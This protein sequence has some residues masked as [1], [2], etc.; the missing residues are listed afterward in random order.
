MIRRAGTRPLTTS[1]TFRRST[2]SQA[3]T[4]THRTRRPSRLDDRP[5]R[6]WRRADLL[7]SPTASR[8]EN[9]CRPRPS[10][11][12]RNFLRG[13]RRHR[14]IGAEGPSSASTWR[15]ATSSPRPFSDWI[16]ERDRSSNMSDERRPSKTSGRSLGERCRA[17]NVQLDLAPSLAQRP[18]RGPRGCRRE[19]VVEVRHDLDRRSGRLCSRAGPRP[20][21]T[22]YQGR[23]A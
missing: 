4:R 17:S 2:G 8:V 19:V 12:A 15:Q 23:T 5:R 6:P 21:V 9:S 16:E 13:S 20:R 1:I 11:L 3:L 22:P 10:A 14:Q 18:V 7:I